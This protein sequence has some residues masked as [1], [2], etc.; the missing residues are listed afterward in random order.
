[1]SMDAL[2]TL[3]QSLD[4]AQNELAAAEIALAEA[5]ARAETARES[6]FRLEAAV[7]AMNGESPPSAASNGGISAGKPAPT[8][9]AAGSASNLDEMTPE[10]FDA[11]R[12]KRQREREKEELANNPL[13]HVKCAG[14]GTNGSMNEQYITAPSGA[15]VRMLVC[16][17]CGNQ[18]L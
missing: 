12:R 14:C 15:P 4:S 8:D 3:E 17:N 13:A 2:E 7:A 9:E 18:V 11:H 16:S 5:N 1:M 6:A 10:E